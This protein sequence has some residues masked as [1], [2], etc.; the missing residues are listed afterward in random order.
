LKPVWALTLLAT[1]PA[2]ADRDDFA[3]DYFTVTGSTARELSAEIDAKSPIGED[4]TH[5]D[6][7]THWHIDWTYNLTSGPAGCA[8]DRIAVNL[9][10]RMTLPRWYP[11]RSADEALVGR[12]NRYVAALRLHEDG[13]RFRAEAAA[14]DVRRALLAESRARD[15]RTL[16]NRLNSRANDLLAD[17]RKRQEAYDRETAHGQTQGV[18]RP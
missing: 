15:C 7:Y 6:G 1:A 16:E 9:A 11:P 10:I 13:H 8:A 3:I 4:G 14:R 18:I 2:F 5:S 12:W 17:L